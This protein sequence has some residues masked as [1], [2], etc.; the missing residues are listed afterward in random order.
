ML[1]Q[2]KKESNKIGLR[3][4]MRSKIKLKKEKHLKRI[5][6]L[7]KSKEWRKRERIK[8]NEKELK[9]KREELKM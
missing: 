1:K 2:H 3:W 7:K 4:M 9:K 6:I 8:K 5:W